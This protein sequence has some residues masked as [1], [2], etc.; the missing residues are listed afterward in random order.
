MPG[1]RLPGRLGMQ[2]GIAVG[3]LECL[4]VTAVSLSKSG[5][6]AA[7]CFYPPAEPRQTICPVSDQKAGSLLGVQAVTL[8]PNRTPELPAV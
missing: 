8:H 5:C 4:K 7:S 1:A 2:L 3:T 6:L